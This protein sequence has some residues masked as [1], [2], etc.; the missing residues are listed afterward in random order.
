M[1]FFGQKGDENNLQYDDTAFL[2]FIASFVSLGAV[3]SLVLILR[4]LWSL[5]IKHKEKLAKN[6]I[7][8]TKI[9]NL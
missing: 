4:D 2:Y 5:S 6:H 7:F 1:S 3:V 8:K 9:S